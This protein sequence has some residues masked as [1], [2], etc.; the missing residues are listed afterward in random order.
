[1][2]LLNE[3]IADVRFQV[4]KT[5]MLEWRAMYVFKK[6]TH[7]CLTRFKDLLKSFTAKTMRKKNCR[8]E[9]IFVSEAAWQISRC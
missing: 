8:L 4:D 7:C 2:E 9:S 5:C 1:M 3:H 6:A